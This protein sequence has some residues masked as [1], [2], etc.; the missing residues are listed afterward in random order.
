MFSR[1]QILV[2]F[3]K[4]Y[5]VKLYL[6]KNNLFVCILFFLSRH[7][8][9]YFVSRN[10]AIGRFCQRK[11]KNKTSTCY[12]TV[13]FVLVLY[14]SALTVWL[15]GTKCPLLY[16]NVLDGGSHLAVYQPCLSKWL[17]MYKA[18][19]VVFIVFAMSVHLIQTFHSW[20]SL[21]LMFILRVWG[22]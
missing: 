1:K 17:K 6:S 18:F 4:L 7:I 2:C 13:V 14:K 12:C 3:V 11:P 8:V 21:V 15:S 9:K 10:S 20:L 19:F 22:P 16:M 5:F